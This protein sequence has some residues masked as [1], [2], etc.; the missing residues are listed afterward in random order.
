MGKRAC[1]LIIFRRFKGPVEYLLMQ[2]SYGEHHWT[3]PKGHVDPGEN[4]MQTALRE[5]EEEAG[6]VRDD[7][8]IFEEAKQ[9]MEYLVKGKSKVVIYWL[10]E[11]INTK[12]DARLSREHQDFKWLPIKEACALAGYSEMQ[13]ALKASDKYIIENV[14][15]SK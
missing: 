13:T 4:D 3:P 15:S 5:T 11:L 2:T 9:E 6:F 10:A 12:K 7:L 1:G 8:K 14:L